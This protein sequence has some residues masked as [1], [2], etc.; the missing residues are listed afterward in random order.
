MADTFVCSI[1][2]NEHEGL[3]TDRAF[4]LPDEVW[5]IPEPKRSEVAKFTNDLCRL[6]ER[7]FVRCVLEVP[8][9]DRDGFFGWGAWAEVEWT[10]FER[11][12]EMYDADGSQESLHKGTLANALSAYPDTLGAQVLIQFR[13]STKRPSMHTLPND[14]SSMAIEQR[15]G[16]NNFR[17]HEIAE[18]FSHGR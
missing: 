6:G 15:R 14:D 11:Y 3:P 18:P 17:F 5:A 10:V 13:E 16:I 9:L 1:C 12:L 8:F 2:G 4:T 7:Y